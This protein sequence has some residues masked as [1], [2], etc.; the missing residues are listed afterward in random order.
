VTPPL[1]AF[2][3]VTVV[4]NGKTVLDGVSLQLNEGEHLAILGPNG[5]GKS[6]LIRTIM[7]EFYPVKRD[8]T[9][10]RCR[11]KDIWDV[12]ELRSAIGIVSN[13]LQTAYA[14][15][16]RGR[17]VVLS[18]FFSSIGLFNHPVT[19]TMVE[20]ADALCR[21][22]DIDRLADRPIVSMSTGEAR[23]FLLARA[24]V[25]DP[26]ALLLDEP[27]NSLDL[28]ALH[29]LRETLREVARSGTTVVV[30]THQL[31]DIIPEC[32][33]VVLMREGRIAADGPKNE[34]LTDER[35]GGLFGA[36]VRLVTENGWY[37]ATG[38]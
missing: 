16:V 23:R 1:L 37:Y 9:V 12:F 6:S 3:N 21:F 35:I 27:T 38:Y 13:D 7:R 32:R 5:A 18:G 15:D 14:R 11:G 24:L 17:E 26:S 28:S 10:F 31:H 33:R 20:K 22:L 19:D 29:T 25:H 36:P 2:E 8:G 34:L 30:V 4:R